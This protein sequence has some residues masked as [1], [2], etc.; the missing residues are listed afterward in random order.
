MTEMI[1]GI[2]KLQ[3]VG[4]AHS[5]NMPMYAVRTLNLRTGDNMRVSLVDDGAIRIEKEHNP[6][7]CAVPGS[8]AQT[9]V[10]QHTSQEMAVDGTGI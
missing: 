6:A 9:A 3:K 7:V 1:L 2:R 5:L 4:G 10:E 8:S